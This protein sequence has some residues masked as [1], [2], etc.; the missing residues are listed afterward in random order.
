MYVYVLFFMLQLRFASYLINEYV[1]RYALSMRHL[2]LATKRS[3]VHV[4]PT[5]LNHN[6][7]EYEG[8]EE[9]LRTSSNF[10]RGDVMEN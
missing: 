2:I 9:I 3:C 5:E 6:L 10:L 4:P 7:N 8:S 1:I